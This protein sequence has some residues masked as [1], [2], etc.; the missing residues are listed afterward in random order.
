MEGMGEESI[1]VIL[2]GTFDTYFPLQPKGSGDS[3]SQKLL[4]NQKT[5]LWK[6]SQ[7][8]TKKTLKNPN[9]NPTNQK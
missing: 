6:K 3:H 2:Y 7:N 8:H 9:N 1:P 5:P 4:I